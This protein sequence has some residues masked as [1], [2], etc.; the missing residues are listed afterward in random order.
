LCNK[1]NDEEMNSRLD[2]VSETYNK[3][4]IGKPIRGISQLRYIMAKYN[5]ENESHVNEILE[6]LNEAL[7]IRPHTGISSSTTSTNKALYYLHLTTSCSKSKDVK[8]R[9]DH[10]IQTFRY[11]YESRL[12]FFIRESVFLYDLLNKE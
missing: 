4:K 8:A 10:V 9:K 6:K 3:G 5:N 12:G 7:E 11:K 2:V 1:A